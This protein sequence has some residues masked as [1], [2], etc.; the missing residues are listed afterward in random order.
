ME[1]GDKPRRPGIGHRFRTASP[2]KKAAVIGAVA[3]PFLVI[4]LV[5]IFF[6]WNWLKGP[7]ESTLSARMGRP[8]HIDGDLQVDLSWTP[9]VV[10]NGVRVENPDWAPD[11]DFATVEQLTAEFRLWP[12]LFG[13]LIFPRIQVESPTIR[14]FRRA[15]GEASWAGS[16]DGDGLTLPEI[17]ALAIENGNVMI[18][19]DVRGIAFV[20]TFNSRQIDEA[21][22]NA[23]ALEGEG[24]LNERP[25]LLQ[26][27]G[28]SLLDAD[29]DEPYGFNAEIEEGSTRITADGSLSG[30][31]DLGGIDADLT[32]SGDD[33][34]ELYYLTGLALPNTPPYELTGHFRR[35]DAEYEFSEFSGKVGDSDVRGN[36]A[37]DASGERPFLTGDV[38]SDR[39]DFDDVAT[40]FGAPPSVGS[41]E[42]ASAVQQAV[43]EQLAAADRLLPD[44]PLQLERVRNMDAEVEFTAREVVSDTLPLTSIALVLSLDDGVLTLD[45]LTFALTQGDVAGTARIDAREEVPS[46][47][48]DFTLREAKLEEFFAMEGGEPALAGDVRARFQ[49][50]GRGISVRETAAHADGRIGFLVPG[51]EIRRAFAELLGINVVEGLGLLLAED[52]SS[53]A[54]RCGI[55]EFAVEDGV[56]SATAFA[57]DT[58]PV[59]VTGE[60][61]VHLETEALDLSVDGHPKDPALVNVMAPITIGGSLRDPE[62]GIEPGAA[63]AQGAAAG[64]LASLLSP[65]AGIIPF[66]NP[67]LQ[68]DANCTALLNAAVEPP[69]PTPQDSPEREG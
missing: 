53:T 19:D 26:L 52:Q 64:A 3:A 59:L 55:A 17:H 33:L 35:S 13:D 68:E 8:V 61:T 54:I 66:L 14:A 28:D 42:T 40:L 41:G 37:V 12:A 45:P 7:L 65:L 31:F 1:T 43:E 11:P 32:F 27:R 20:G 2:R 10:L 9:E 57:I 63:I 30:A 36:V 23:F 5:A 15:V 58:E 21:G 24:T 50:A 62:L 38:A 46:S 34:A 25:F 47:E 4:A 39:L 67:G 16:G 18:D 56:L 51:G 49:L 60:G 69:N 6:E 29:A 48:I 22:G 44:A